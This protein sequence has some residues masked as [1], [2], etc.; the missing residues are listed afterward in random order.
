MQKEL[1]YLFPAFNYYLDNGYGP[2][3]AWTRALRVYAYVYRNPSDPQSEFLGA[4]EI[5]LGDVVDAIRYI[6]N[7]IVS[8]EKEAASETQ[9]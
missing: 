4:S 6:V 8:K 7:E 9:S 5:M 2:D 1:G 3:E